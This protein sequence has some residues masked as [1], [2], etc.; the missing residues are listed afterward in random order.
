M[1]LDK[2]IIGFGIVAALVV[3]GGVFIGTNRERSETARPTVTFLECDPE[4]AAETASGT[5]AQWLG[6]D[7][8]TASRNRFAVPV[9]QSKRAMTLQQL[10]ERRV[11]VDLDVVPD[12]DF[13][14]LHATLEIV[15]TRCTDQQIESR[16]WAIYRL[17]ASGTPVERLKTKIKDRVA[18]AKIKHNSKYAIAD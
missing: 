9:G 8:V 1:A 16:D 3:A 12:D 17:D 11:S 5:A 13:N 10:H 15:L 18:S 2:R 7:V 6:G 4:A 14:L